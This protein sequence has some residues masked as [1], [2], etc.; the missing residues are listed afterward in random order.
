[1]AVWGAK[2][3]NKGKRKGLSL[4]KLL[5]A[6]RTD[7]GL[8]RSDNEDAYLE[9]PDL[10]LLVVADGMGGAAAGEVASG[11]FIDVVMEVFDNKKNTTYKDTL[12]LVKKAFETANSR[13]L[14]H[15]KVHPAHKGMGCTAELMAFFNEGYVL[16]HV[17]DSRTYL[18]REGRLVQITKDHSLVQVQ[19]D[20]GVISEF[21]A[22]SQSHKNI[23]LRAVGVT[24]TLEIDIR[25][26]KFHPGDIFLLCSDGLTDMVEDEVLVEVL[27]TP[28]A[29]ETKA[30]GL[31]ELAKVVGGEDNITV[32]MGQILE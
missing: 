5:T 13:I 1:V 11:I 20:M 19:I 12:A 32:V 18:Y 14:D 15:V 29:L 6:G 31:I 10:G 8:K 7:A 22:R 24:D 23:I 3:E 2:Q 27:S 9:R 17:G 30:E 28:T 16:G 4:A 21:E 26:I 25:G